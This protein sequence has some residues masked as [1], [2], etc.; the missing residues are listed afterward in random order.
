[1]PLF[2]ERMGLKPPQT[3]PEDDISESTSNCLWNA[4]YESYFICITPSERLPWHYG[5]RP[6]CIPRKTMFEKLWLDFFEQRIDKMPMPESFVNAFDILYHNLSGFQKFDFV[7]AIWEYGP[8][9]SRDSFGEKCDKCL[10]KR[11]EQYR[12]VE[13]QVVPDMPDEEK[14]S[15]EDA[16]EVEKSFDGKDSRLKQ[17]LFHLSNR[18]DPDYLSSMQNS[19]WALEL[20]IKEVAGKEV[21][22]KGFGTALAKLEEKVELEKSLKDSISSLYG[23]TNHIGV[24]HGTPVKKELKEENALFLLVTCSAYINYI[25]HL[26][27]RTNEDRSSN[28]D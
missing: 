2:T 13:G 6:F 15:V 16:I 17:A 1:M 20:V 8:P 7:E 10:K 14:K 26:P 18:K 4:V 11:D 19:I 22:T 9:E 25:R 5:P 12:F 27:A 21:A 28:S 24:R 3:Q 23:W